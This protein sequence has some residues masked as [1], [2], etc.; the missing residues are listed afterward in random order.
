MF[1]HYPIEDF[2]DLYDEELDNFFTIFQGDNNNDSL[3]PK[4]MAIMQAKYAALCKH[5]D[6]GLLFPYV[7]PREAL[8]AVIFAQLSEY[9]KLDIFG[10]M[11]AG[12]RNKE[13]LKYF[14]LQ[15]N[16]TVDRNF[17]D[18]VKTKYDC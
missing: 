15:A 13:K 6:R 4:K 1:N 7:T 2:I 12:S 8:L 18:R 9:D 5:L 11:V 3:G 16:E 17:K 10:N 14:Y